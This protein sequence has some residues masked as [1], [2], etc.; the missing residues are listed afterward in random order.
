MTFLHVLET[1]DISDCQYWDM[2]D[3]F[4]IKV[5]IK[6]SNEIPRFYCIIMWANVSVVILWT[7][8]GR[9]CVLLL[10]DI[11]RKDSSPGLNVLLI[12]I[13]LKCDITN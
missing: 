13:I 12:E 10:S 8:H 9:D 6:Y 1:P 7:V 11:N 3:W 4:C 5:Q 2:C